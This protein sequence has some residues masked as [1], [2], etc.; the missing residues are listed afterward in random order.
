MSFAPPK[1]TPKGL[2][3]RTPPAMFPPVLGLMGLG[4]AWRRGVREFALPPDLA[5]LFLGAVT[6]LALF[7]L[8]AYV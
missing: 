4:I 7:T 2:F 6:L 8:L 5:E 3:R 1:M